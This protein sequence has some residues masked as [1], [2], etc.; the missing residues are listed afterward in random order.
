[1]LLFSSAASRHQ[2]TFTKLADC[3]KHLPLAVSWAEEAWG[4]MRGSLGVE[5]RKERFSDKRDQVYI[6]TLAN[7]PVAMF[8]LFDHEFHPDLQAGSKR[9]PQ[10]RELTYV[11]V[12]KDYR[13]FGFARQIVN[14]AK[15]L[16]KLAGAD[17]IVL[18]TLKPNLTH[19][20]EKQ[21]GVAVCEGRLGTEPTELMR[22]G[23]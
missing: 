8:A 23:V 12:D 6:G 22:M 20:Y 7:Q 18:D 17:L 1:M 3:M 15:R 5:K 14:E 13:N 16:A 9:L 4:Y 2:L 11:Y 19:M 10:V 21:G